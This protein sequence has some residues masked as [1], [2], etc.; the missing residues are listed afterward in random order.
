M[1]RCKGGANVKTKIWSSN[2]PKMRAWAVHFYTSLGL[3]AG[4]LALIAVAEGR[5]RDVFLFL[6]LALWIDSTDGMLARG[7]EV[8][9][10]TPRFDG[11]KLD[12][13][14]DYLNYVFIPVFFIYHFELV[15]GIWTLVLPL[16][17]LA[18]AYGFCNKA[19]KTEDGY[20]TGFPSY[21]NVLAFYFYLLNS[22]SA[23]VGLLLLFFTLMVFV[24]IKYIYPSRTPIL[25]QLNIGLGFF[26][27]LIICLIMINFKHP[28][29]RLVYLSL[30]YPVYYM[31]LSFYLHFRPRFDSLF[32]FSSPR[33]D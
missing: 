31:L 3:I 23:G 7:W 16:V 9:T 29:P 12:D 5:P 18:S 28:D 27:F 6:G 4:L 19:A 11:R 1:S 2:L 8:I 32:R 22:P 30:I 15:S 13:I 10:W 33:G 24:P 14:T 17:L 25:R 26:W 20:F 21:W